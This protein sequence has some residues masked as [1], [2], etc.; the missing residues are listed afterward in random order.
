MCQIISIWFR[1]HVL[2]TSPT[3]FY[4]SSP[5]SFALRL[6][7]NNGELNLRADRVILSFTPR[8]VG[9]LWPLSGLGARSVDSWPVS[10]Q[11]CR[12]CGLSFPWRIWWIPSAWLLWRLLHIGSRSWLP[13]GGGVRVPRPVLGLGLSGRR[14]SSTPGPTGC[15]CSTAWTVSSPWFP[16]ASSG[17]TSRL[18]SWTFSAV[19]L[20]ELPHPG[21]FRTFSYSRVCLMLLASYFP[22]G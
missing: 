22:S 7:K 11:I 17:V 1:L 19:P 21:L 16:P 3:C 18:S 8:R 14:G 10:W 2:T 15:S 4:S 9:R 5:S 20:H 13:A 12:I 6:R